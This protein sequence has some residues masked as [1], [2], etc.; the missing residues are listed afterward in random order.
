[1]LVFYF[2]EIIH[3]ILKP[4]TSLKL[5]FAMNSHIMGPEKNLGE[6]KPR[7]TEQ[8]MDIFIVSS[9]IYVITLFTWQIKTGRTK[10]YLF[11]VKQYHDHGE[12]RD[13]WIPA[14]SEQGAK[15]E[16]DSPK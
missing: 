6:E 3:V 7:G 16:M 5:T 1:M 15:S 12:D 10:T 11:Y 8:W 4:L 13:A 2:F 14:M 9:S